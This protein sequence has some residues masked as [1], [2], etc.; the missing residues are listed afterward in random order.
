MNIH[1]E[2]SLVFTDERGEEIRF[3]IQEQTRVN[4][5][6]YLLVTDS[7]EE[8]ATAYILKD[9]SAD[10]DETAAY[11]MVEDGV[12]F[13]AIADVF[14]RMMEEADVDLIG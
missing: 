11:V 6:D 4:G 8:E 9:T 13:D 5:T 10:G 14:R 3:Y 7:D 12:E 1:E 2:A